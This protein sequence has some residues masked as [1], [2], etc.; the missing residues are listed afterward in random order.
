MIFHHVSS[1]WIILTPFSS[2]FITSCFMIFHHLSA[3]SLTVHHFHL[4]APAATLFIC[5]SLSITFMIFDTLS[6]LLHHFIIFHD[7]SR[8]CHTFHHFPSFSLFAIM[9]IIIHHFSSCLNLF[10]GCSSF[11]SCFI[12]FT[13]R[14]DPSS[15]LS[16]ST[17]FH[18]VL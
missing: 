1:S 9:F 17:R 3:I 15:F 5:S 18:Y 16:F 7:F 12:T 6:C 14:R 13:I 2:S 10:Y 8:L 11:L 4:L